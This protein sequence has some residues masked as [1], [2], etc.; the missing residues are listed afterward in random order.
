MERWEGKE[1]PHFLEDG[2]NGGSKTETKS[3]SSRKG[4]KCNTKAT[5]SALRATWSLR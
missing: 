1:M 3:V 4:R 2:G 5:Y